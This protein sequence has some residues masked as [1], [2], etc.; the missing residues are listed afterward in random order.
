MLKIAGSLN[1]YPA[2]VTAIG[3]AL[4]IVAGTL[5]LKLPGVIQSDRPSMTFVDA[6]FMC[7]SAVCVTGLSVRSLVDDFTIFG[8]FLMLLLIQTGGLGIMTLTTFVLLATGARGG[9]R[10]HLLI[11]STLTGQSKADIKLLLKRV[12]VFTFIT[13]ACGMVILFIRFLFTDMSFGWALWNAIFLP[14]SSFCNAGFAL[15]NYSLIPFQS[16]FLVLGTTAALIIIG[17]LG[18]PV[19]FDIAS[20]YKKNRKNWWIDLHIHSKIMLL[21]T[22]VL[23]TCGFLSILALEWDNPLTSNMTT[24][25]RVLSALFQSITCRTAGFN[26]VNLLEYGNATLIVMMLLMFIGAG[27]CSTAGGVKVST[28]AMIF[29]KA[30]SRFRSREHVSAFR[31]TIPDFAIDRAVTTVMLYVTVALVGSIAILA[32]EDF[33]S[34]EINERDEFLKNVFEVISALGTV[35][36]SITNTAEFLPPS[37]IVLVMLMFVGRIGPIAFFSA[38]STSPKKAALTYASEEPLTG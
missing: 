15:D 26:S 24:Y 38:L 34:A 25:E 30:T 1:R 22:T 37:K 11:S 20:C 8:Q 16:D 33:G 36:L 31:R 5:L 10:Q 6:L 32:F 2:R 17:G 4:L 18:Y 7:T 27:P 29:G 13:E 35:G 14:I 23:I 19:F 21:G 9:M 3:F 12:I 28:I